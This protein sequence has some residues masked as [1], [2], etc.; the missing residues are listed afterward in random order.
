MAAYAK[1]H[2]KLSARAKAANIRFR[3]SK[4]GQAHLY[5]DTVL[6]GQSAECILFLDEGTA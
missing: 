4:I 3:L 5:D 2:S 6:D 1:T